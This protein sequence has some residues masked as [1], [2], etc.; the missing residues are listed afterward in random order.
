MNISTA[1]VFTGVALALAA[2][3]NA[4]PDRTTSVPP[5][6]KSPTALV[7]PIVSPSAPPAPAMREPAP[8]NA[9]DAAPGTNASVAFA[10]ETLAPATKQP[11]KDG[12]PAM[13]AAAVD[14]Q[15]ASAKAPTTAAADDAKKEV[16][17]SESRKAG[18][19]EDT[20]ANSPRHGTLTAREESTQMPKAGQA[21][22]YSSPAL[23]K[24][25]GRPSDGS[26]ANQGTAK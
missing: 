20:A 1:F 22:N 8:A 25:S 16:M 7:E 14:A 17:T 12:A 9:N 5:G 18:T 21:N 23:E 4:D 26:T 10:N 3:N 2:C 19:A 6:V 11:S 13:Q 15:E 24:D